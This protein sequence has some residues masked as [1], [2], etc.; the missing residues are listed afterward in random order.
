MSENPLLYRPCS[1]LAIETEAVYEG[2]HPGGF[3]P[4]YS[5]RK[6][7]KQKEGKFLGFSVDTVYEYDEIVL[8][9]VAIVENL[10]GCV[11]SVLLKDF[12]FDDVK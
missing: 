6:V 8:R 7:P 10:D 4:K 9:T 11:V 2:M 5:Y 1:Y 3:I 12:K